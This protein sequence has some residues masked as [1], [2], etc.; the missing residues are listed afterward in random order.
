M[1]GFGLGRG[2]IVV[3]F[4]FVVV[5]AAAR[6]IVG[7]AIVV[8]TKIGI[9]GLLLGCRGSALGTRPRVEATVVVRLLKN[10][11]SFSGNFSSWEEGASSS[12]PLSLFSMAFFLGRGG[13]PLTFLFLRFG[14]A[15]PTNI[16]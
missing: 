5:I 1:P 10:F 6:F 7:I 16:L 13:R 12:L 3:A 14:T 8:E 11:F 9:L 15:F 4:A 2:S